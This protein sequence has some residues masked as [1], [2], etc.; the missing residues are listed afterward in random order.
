MYAVSAGLCI[1]A[2]SVALGVMAQNA[3]RDPW[4]VTNTSEMPKYKWDPT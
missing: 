2:V 4:A 3:A 1:L